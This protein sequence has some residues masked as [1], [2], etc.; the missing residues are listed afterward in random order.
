MSCCAI[1]DQRSATP[2]VRRLTGNRAPAHLIGLSGAAPGP[3]CVLALARLP[4]RSVTTAAVLPSTQTSWPEGGRSTLSDICG[5]PVFAERTSVDLDVDARFLV[6][7]ALDTQTGEDFITGIRPALT[8]SRSRRGSRACRAGRRCCIRESVRTALRELLEF[9]AARVF[10]VRRYARRELHI[11]ER[12]AH[13]PKVLVDQAGA[14][15]VRIPLATKGV[16][17]PQHPE[18]RGALSTRPCTRW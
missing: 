15:Q 2:R 4:L 1:A 10:A 11:T 8:H 6:V 3:R 14:V 12:N 7:H 5:R 17:L 9:E 13:R 18:N 16:F